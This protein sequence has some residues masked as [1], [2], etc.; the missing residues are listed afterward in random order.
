MTLLQISLSFLKIGAIGFGGPI[1]LVAFME[2]EFCARRKI[3]DR[4]AFNESYV[5]CKMLPG[6]VAYQMALSVGH[7]LRGRRGGLVAGIAFLLPSFVLML[8]LAA[9]YSKVQT[10]GGFER[11]A[12]GFRAGAVVVIIDSVLR[13]AKPYRTSPE[14][15]AFA[16]VGALFM[17]LWPRYEPVIILSGGLAMVWAGKRIAK[18]VSVLWPLF[19]VHFKAGAFTF[20]TGL[21]IVP[22]LQHETVSVF[23]WVTDREFLDGVA[24]GQITPGPITIASVFFGY[25]AAGWIG[26]T[27][28]ALGVYLPGAILVLGLLPGLRRRLTGTP[29]LE[30]FQRGAVPTVIGCILAAS[31]AFSLAVLIDRSSA[32]VFVVCAVAAW[33]WRP[34]AWALIAMG[35]ALNFGARA[36][37]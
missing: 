11:L 15:W 24:F 25:R 6:P 31:V 10:L 23:H 16:A 29:F 3:I 17:G 8:A 13:M 21:A 30:R 32:V 4:G 26:G 20:G 14:A 28:A 19:W 2:E 36:I 33:R 35:G 34:P 37:L 9:L 12:E 1:A 7:L 27:V 22:L 5:L 18:K